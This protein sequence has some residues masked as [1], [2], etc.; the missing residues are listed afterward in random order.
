MSSFN[1]VGERVAIPLGYL[2]TALA[3]HAWATR[4]V[5]LVCA[6]A[7]VATTALNL[8]V[9]DVYRVNRI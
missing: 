1:G 2:V 5:L 7:I 4:T 3:A 8:C 9:R 6:G